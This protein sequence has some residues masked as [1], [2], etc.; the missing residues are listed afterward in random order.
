MLV[1]ELLNATNLWSPSNPT[2]LSAL[3]HTKNLAKKM[4]E[5]QVFLSKVNIVGQESEIAILGVISV[6]LKSFGKMY[7]GLLTEVENLQQGLFGGV[8]FEDE[9]WF[10]FKVPDIIADDPNCIH[11][12]YFF[13]DHE[14]ND[15]HKYE[16]AGINVLLNHPRLCNRFAFVRG[17]DELVMNVVACHDFLRRA[18]HARSKLASACHTSLGGP[19]RGSEFAA[20]Y[21]RNHPRGDVRHV[22]FIFGSLSLGATSYFPTNNMLILY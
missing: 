5:D 13:A 17:G 1:P 16:E 15:L 19:P 20:N 9:E 12:G 21:V 6:K 11:P 4:A 3:Y 22:N 18:E 14:Y 2:T 7:R 10:K 8:S